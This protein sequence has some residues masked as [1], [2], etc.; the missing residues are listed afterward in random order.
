MSEI[1]DD[2][3]VDDRPVDD[4]LADTRA[5]RPHWLATGVAAAIIAAVVLG[6]IGLDAVIAAPSAGT[7]TVGRSV[8]MTA[9]DGWVLVSPAGDTS[10]GIE[11]QKG[12]AILTAQVVATDYPGGAASVLADAR[13]TLDAGAAQISYSEVRETTVGGHDT[14]SVVFEATVASGGPSGVVDG[15]LICMIVGRDAVAIVVAAPQ[16]D[17]D[18]LIDDVTAMLRSVEGGS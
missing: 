1:A 11:L 6:G 3:P 4:R 5:D 17:L 14:A 8:T 18:P 10:A 15:E 13:R 2:R 9:A 12:N 7:V 16:G